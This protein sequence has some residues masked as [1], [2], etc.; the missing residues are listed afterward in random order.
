MGL[1][2]YLRYTMEFG[3]HYTTFHHYFSTK[4]NDILE[5]TCTAI[6]VILWEKTLK[7]WCSNF[8]Y[9][10]VENLDEESQCIFVCLFAC[11]VHVFLW[12]FP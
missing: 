9:L 10:L 11:F 6:P 1:I 4:I 3:H 5:N 8:E 2:K 7:N 12:Q